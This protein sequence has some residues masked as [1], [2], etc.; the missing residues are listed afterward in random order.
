MSENSGPVVTLNE[1]IE[2]K[3]PKK[4]ERIL[5]EL[6][7]ISLSGLYDQLIMAIEEERYED[8]KTLLHQLISQ[9]E[10]QEANENETLARVQAVRTESSTDFKTVQ[11]LTEYIRETTNTKTQRTAGISA[12]LGFAESEGESGTKSEVKQSAKTAKDQEQKFE[13]QTKEIQDKVDESTVPASISITK[14]SLDSRQIKKE[15]PSRLSVTAANVGDKPA[16]EVKI[17]VESPNSIRVK[18]STFDIGSVASNE[19][20]S[21][22]TTIFGNSSGT[23]IITVTINAENCNKSSQTLSVHVLGSESEEKWYDP[24]VNENDVVTTSGLN[25]AVRH[26]LTGKLGDKKFNTVVRAYLT[27]API[28]E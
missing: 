22:S 23:Y 25:K 27:G 9:Y 10:K 21:R 19:K 3:D 8:A 18:K 16:Q 5:Q 1:A 2:A 26:Y 13:K 14:A 6:E 11:E 17:D 20:E 15:K 24:Y 4:I 7:T 12:V 28:E